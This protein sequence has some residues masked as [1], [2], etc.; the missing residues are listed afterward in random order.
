MPP[1]QREILLDIA[2]NPDARLPDVYRRLNR[3][4][5][6]VKRGLDVLHML[7]LLHCTEVSTVIAGKRHTV[8]SYRLDAGFDQATLLAM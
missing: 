2:A 6:T 7:R 1:L 3:P 4:R 8:Q 5:T